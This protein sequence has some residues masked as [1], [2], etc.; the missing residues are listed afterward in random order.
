MAKDIY[1]DRRDGLAIGSLAGGTGGM[2]L[3]SKIADIVAPVTRTIGKLDPSWRIQND[4]G[5]VSLP[6]TVVQTVGQHL[7]DQVASGLI[8]T[9]GVA[10]LIAGGAVGV[11]LANKRH[12]ATSNRQHDG[13]PED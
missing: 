5:S 1:K 8:P 4:D 3:G 13:T 11:H 9:L 7:H 2:A 6:N 10:G 12:G